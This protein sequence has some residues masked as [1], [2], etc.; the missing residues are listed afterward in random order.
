MIYQEQITNI[1]DSSQITTVFILIF[2]IILMSLVFAKFQIFL[3]ALVIELFSLF[4]GVYSLSIAIPL[5]PF[6]Q[7]FF[8]TYQA[9]LFFLISSK[10]YKYKRNS[11]Y[12]G[13]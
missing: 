1:I 7:I 11:F 8:L 6:F 4:F 2:M 3:L 10:A 9:T 12:E 5:A 13:D